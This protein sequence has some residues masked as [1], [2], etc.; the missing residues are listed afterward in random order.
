MIFLYVVKQIVLQETWFGINLKQ[1]KGEV[2]MSC[3]EAQHDRAN[4][5]PSAT[6]PGITFRPAGLT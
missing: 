3:T 5:S 6:E 1:P 4:A 2:S